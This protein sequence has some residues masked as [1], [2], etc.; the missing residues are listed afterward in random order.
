V[1]ISSSD[2]DLVWLV[3]V[4]VCLHAAPRVQVSDSPHT[5]CAARLPWLIGY[6]LPC[7]S[8]L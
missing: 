1:S 8:R 6:Y 5:M 2:D 4:M 7:K 3:V